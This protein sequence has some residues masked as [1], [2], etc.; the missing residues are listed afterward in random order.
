MITK[1]KK[2]KKSDD[3]VSFNSVWDL[4]VRGGSA[5]LIETQHSEQMRK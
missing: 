1:K 5:D 3:D 4:R 2:G